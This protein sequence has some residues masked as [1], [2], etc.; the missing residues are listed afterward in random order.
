MPPLTAPSF[1]PAV[2]S[3]PHV[4]EAAAALW[5]RAAEFDQDGADPAGL[6]RPLADAGL[7][8]AALPSAFGGEGLAQASSELARILMTIGGADLSAGRIFEGHVNAVKLV[9]AYG[10]AVQKRRLAEDVRAGAVCGVWNAEAPPGLRWAPTQGGAGRLQGAKIYASGLGLVTR[11]IITARTEDGEGL[12]IA[13]RLE[14][15]HPCDLSGWTVQGMRA[16]AT[17]TIDF[18]GREVNPDEVIGAPGDYYRSPYFKGGA[19]RFAAVHAGAVLRLLGLFRRELRARRR[20]GDPH[21]RARLGTAAIAAETAELWIVRAAERIEEG[22]L[23]PAAADAYASLARLA[24]ERA[25]LDMLTLVERGVGL[26]AFTRP[27]PIERVARDLSTYLRQPF[28]DG[29]LE[30][31]GGFIAGTEAPPW[32][33]LGSF[34]W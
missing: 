11:P 19:W 32:S 31:G 18:T 24:V 21:Q 4:L 13:P 14:P 17:G 8:V 20:D 29:V 6:C 26:A 7:F 12:M 9:F 3:A 34:P 27:N 30:E 2:P 33:A 22:G 28:P 10:D 25:A 15:G 23:D 5:R 16:T 1:S